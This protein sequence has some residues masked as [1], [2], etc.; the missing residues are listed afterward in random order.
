MGIF[1]SPEVFIKR[2]AGYSQ[3]EKMKR[4]MAK[5]LEHAMQ[6]DLISILL[7]NFVTEEGLKLLSDYYELEHFLPESVIEEVANS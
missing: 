4:E 2:C 1:K 3:T 6:V 7:D 5:E